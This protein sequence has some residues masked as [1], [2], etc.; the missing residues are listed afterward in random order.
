MRFFNKE[1]IRANNSVRADG[2]IIKLNQIPN[3]FYSCGS[4][5]IKN[6][7]FINVNVQRVLC[8]AH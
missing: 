1:K 6:K 2:H 3:R 4:K 8:G 7:F 5:Q